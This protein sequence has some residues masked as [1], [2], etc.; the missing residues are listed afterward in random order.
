M[1][2]KL[3]YVNPATGYC[4]EAEVEGETFEKVVDA[5]THEIAIRHWPSINTVVEIL[6]EEETKE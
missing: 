3:K 4:N 1:K 5:A 6:K 2:A